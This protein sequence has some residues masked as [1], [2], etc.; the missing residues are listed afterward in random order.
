MDINKRNWI[1]WDDV[2]HCKIEPGARASYALQYGDLVVARMADPGKSAI[3]EEEI[4]AVFASYLVRLKTASLARSYYVY[5]FLKS[6]L[7]SEYAQGATSG[8]VQ[9]NMNAKVIVG[10]SL[11]IPTE[12]VIERFFKAVLPFRQCL[13]ANVRESRT[14][15]TLRDTLLP[16]LSSGEV[17]LS[18]EW[19][20]SLGTGS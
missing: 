2:P 10:A 14:L 19:V 13:V 9:A 7:Y 11:V 3:V 1:E 6:D 15:A 5:G 17:R 8:S 20:R 16:K 4:E 18:S 12:A